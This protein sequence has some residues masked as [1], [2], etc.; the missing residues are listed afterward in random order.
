[1]QKNNF[2]K[3][4][5]AYFNFVKDK[6][7]QNVLIEELHAFKNIYIKS[8]ELISALAYG[9]IDSV[10]VL[11]QFSAE[12]QKFLRILIKDKAILAIDKIYAEFMRLQNIERNQAY[13]TISSPKKLTD[14]QL[15][16]LTLELKKIIQDKDL[17]LRQEINPKLINGLKID[18]AG[19]SLDLSLLTKLKE[20]FR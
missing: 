5:H 16:T 20:M 14:K 11:A 1:M 2:T 8:P 4:A 6:T 19:L 9:R 15:K 3:Y 12:T 18:Y 7:Q 17:I 13:V 10:R